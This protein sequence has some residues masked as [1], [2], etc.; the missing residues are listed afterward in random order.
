MEFLNSGPVSQKQIRTWTRTDPVLSRVLELT[1]GG[2]AADTREETAELRPYRN[3]Q[4]EL[5]VEN[6]C[7]L[8]GG[9]IVI[10]PQGRKVVLSQLHEGHFGVARMKSFGRMY[11]GLQLLWYPLR[12][13]LF[14]ALSGVLRNYGQ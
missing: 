3:R 9:R 7:V 4:A 14:I 1:R 8:W 2:W 6:D 10:P 13:R 5:S 12:S 11:R